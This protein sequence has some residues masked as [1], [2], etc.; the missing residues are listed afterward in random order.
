MVLCM[1]EFGCRTH[2]NTIY[3]TMKVL[4]FVTDLDLVQFGLTC[5]TE[6]D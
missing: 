1:T 2:W 4:F 3:W 6:F 5:L